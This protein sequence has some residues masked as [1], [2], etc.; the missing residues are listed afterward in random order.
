MSYGI[1]WY[2]K[3]GSEITMEQ[4]SALLG[5]PYIRVAETFLDGVRVSTVWLGLDHNFARFLH[6]PGIPI[7]FE[8]MIFGGEL[9]Q[10]QWRYATEAQ[11]L[12]GHAAA[13]ELVRIQHQVN[14]PDAEVIRPVPARVLPSLDFIKPHGHEGEHHPTRLSPDLPAPDLDPDGEFG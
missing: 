9:D 2:A 13:V 8:T 12:D 3:D 1:R 5:T 4:W 7:I 14:M 11:A 10:Q 6:D